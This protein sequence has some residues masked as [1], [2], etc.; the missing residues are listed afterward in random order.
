MKPSLLEPLGST[1]GL[2]VVRLA[3]LLLHA[4]AAQFGFQAV[5]AAFAAGQPG[6]E[7]HAMS[8]KVEDG[9]SYWPQA[10]HHLDQPALLVALPQ[11]RA[12]AAAAAAALP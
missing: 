12:S 8:V 6:G 9:T 2:G 4:E 3:I 7:H 10:C 5:A 11:A 1:L